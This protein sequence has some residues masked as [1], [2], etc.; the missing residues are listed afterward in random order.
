MTIRKINYV[1]IAPE[2]EQEIKDKYTKV[3]TDN[4]LNNKEDKAKKGQSNGYA[5]LDTNAKIPLS[6][7]PDTA[8]QQ[9]Y[10]VNSQTERNA[11]SGLIQGDK[12]FEVSTGNSYIWNG[13]SWL[14]TSKADW[15]NIN[16][17]W[18]N[19]V[20][21]PN[22]SVVDIDDSVDKKHDHNNLSVLQTITQALVN[23]WNT[24]GNK[25]DKVTGK[26]LSTEDYTPVEKNKL[27]GI[28]NNANNYTHP[29][30]AGNKHVPS[31]GASGQFL[32][33]DANGAAIW[34]SVPGGVELGESSGNAYRGDRGKVAYDHSQSP[35]API[36][37]GLIIP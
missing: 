18:S 29:T 21:K 6:Q 36:D 31:G 27:A 33:W 34:S 16:L 4:K 20:D 32:K 22:S 25:V 37:A 13:V 15:E 8:K 7:L 3:E 12:C 30:T 26:G 14:V 35:H 28:E 24:I 11:L 23:S 5:S 9:T 2:V 19:I 1:V 10:V 17:Q